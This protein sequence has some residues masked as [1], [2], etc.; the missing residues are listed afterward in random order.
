MNDLPYNLKKPSQDHVFN[1]DSV[2]LI[3]RNRSA[4]G[5]WHFRRRGLIVLDLVCSAAAILMAYATVPSFAFTWESTAGTQPGPFQATIIFVGFL[6]LSS[7]VAGMHDPLEERK[8]WI[9]FARVGL[10]VLG[11]LGLTLLLLYF[12]SLQQ[13][14]RTILLRT[15]LISVVLLS[16]ARLLIW[17][18]SGAT[19]RRVGYYFKDKSAEGLRSLISSPSASFK[20]VEAPATGDVIDWSQVA[21]SFVQLQIDEVIVISRE[22]QRDLWLACLKQGLQVTDV[23]VFVEREY[24]KIACDEVDLSW[25]LAIDLKWNHPFYHR[26]KRLTDI[27]IASVGLL[28]LAPVMMVAGLLVVVESGRPVLYSQTRVGFRGRGYRLWKI[29]TMRNDAEAKGPQWAQKQDG[30]VTRIGRILR[31]TRI[32]ELPQFWNVLRGDMSFIGP[33]PERP[34]FVDKLSSLIPLYSQRHWVK[35]GITGWAQINYP[36]G[37]SVE[38]AREKLCYDLYYMKNASL[39]LDLHIGLRTI[40]AVMKGSR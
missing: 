31:L 32:D 36:Y 25:M 11:A 8:V 38:D 27:A 9:V 12:V 22:N 34:E 23:A 2:N 6:V 14:G 13:L 21:H 16:G 40:G 10:S 17:H 39:L 19:P 1:P 37:A 15:S 26:F 35:P 5:F 20:L 30:R 3:G 24:Y 18:F 7:H 28:L 33:R 4:A 29:R